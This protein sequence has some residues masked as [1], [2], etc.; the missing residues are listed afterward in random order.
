M[1]F[2]SYLN[3]S[4]NIIKKWTVLAKNNDFSDD[5]KRN[6]LDGYIKMKSRESIMY[7]VGAFLV[8]FA[9]FF[10]MGGIQALN[11]NVYYF[12]GTD[13]IAVS[14][15]ESYVVATSV[16]IDGDTNKIKCGGKYYLLP[17]KA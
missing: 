10:M 16:W 7:P 11:Q 14:V 2:S 6:I 12:V 17:W 9:L 4:D 13:K 1:G 3:A 5:D 15:Y 8:V